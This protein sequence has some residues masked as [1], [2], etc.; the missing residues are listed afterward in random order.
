MQHCSIESRLMQTKIRCFGMNSNQVVAPDVHEERIECIRNSRQCSIANEWDYARLV[1]RKVASKICTREVHRS[2][3]QVKLIPCLDPKRATSM[4]CLGSLDFYILYGSETG[5]AQD[6]AERIGREA[7]RRGLKPKILPADY[8]LASIHEFP[9]EKTV[10]FV[11]STTGQGDFPSNSVGFWKFL[12]R[13]ALAHD[14]LSNVRVA[15]FGLGDSGYLKYN[16]CA[17]LLYRRLESLGAQP[18]V[19]LGLGDDQH[20]YGYDAA[21]DPWLSKLWIALGVS[22]QM[23]ARLEL[24]PARI[25]NKFHVSVAHDGP[26][27]WNGDCETDYKNAVEAGTA[28]RRL[29][30]S[31]WSLARQEVDME[32]ESEW[33]LT[34]VLKNTRV[35]SND[36]FQDVRLIEID[37]K[38]TNKRFY[39]G[40]SIAVWPQQEKWAVDKVLERCGLTY[41][42]KVC[43]SMPHLGS[44]ISLRAGD[45]VS[46]SID[47]YGAPPRRTFFEA[48]ARD[49]PEGM[50][51]DRLLHLASPVGRGDL[52]EYV[53]QEGRNVL[54]VLEDFKCVTITLEMLLT[55]APRL[56]PRYYSAASSLQQLPHSVEVLVAL[57]E[58]KTPGR[59]LRR[60]LCSKYIKSLGPGD[61]IIIGISKGSIRLPPPSVPMI[62]IGPGTGVAPFRS[63]LQERNALVTQ[64][65]YRDVVEPSSLYFGC[66]SR[67]KDFFFK[68]EWENMTKSGVLGGPAGGLVT[69]FS[70]DSDKKVYVTHQIRNNAAG[71]WKSISHDAAAIFVAGSA[72]KM[73]MDVEHALIYAIETYGGMDY[74]SAKRYLKK[75]ESTGRYQVECWS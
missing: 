39:P 32:E 4:R 58:W 8:Y 31:S 11:V 54:E 33:S 44:S 30:A 68:A 34:Q 10:V 62:L 55:T 37:L 65:G 73:P 64:H 71:I 67:L 60:G 51:K 22:E 74:D 17:K 13:K 27:T 59:R 18:I 70:R 75:L 40:D 12:R 21:L 45:V 48:L 7:A 14:F 66:R 29:E 49:C 53:S 5:N 42:S 16:Y 3:L 25:E 69:A 50:Y 38:C 47:I 26:Q 24:E 72:G 9:L 52:D 2:Q 19:E 36:H 57:V 1:G 6:A 56:Q 20:P 35:T 63:F 15:V 61:E 23:N 41:N 43:I 46:G 28:L